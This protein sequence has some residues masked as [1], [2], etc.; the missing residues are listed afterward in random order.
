L[1][2]RTQG[3]L[4]T[5]LRRAA[6]TITAMASVSLLAAC[7]TPRGDEPC[8]PVVGA[9]VGG[10]VGALVGGER[11]RARG[12]ALG[13]GVGALA[14]M[15]INY[16]SR[17]TR[18]ADQVGDE[19]RRRNG[20]LPPAPMVASYTT[21]AARSSARAGEDITVTST[22]EVVPGRNEPLKELREEFV[23]VDPKGVE[24]SKLA[25]T[26]APSGSRGGAYVSTLQFTFPQG[27]PPGAYRVQS[28][29][30]VNGKAAQTSA[31]SIQVAAAAAHRPLLAAAR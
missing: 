19:Y 26:P 31:V 30:F 5:A 29:L 28:R 25:K 24:R 3:A 23:I 27:V 9:V 6:P 21:Q 22:I 18:S 8:N 15:A 14:C 2:I 17:Q 4:E 7:A 11:H 20:E 13:A 10:A 12:A 16:N 1:K